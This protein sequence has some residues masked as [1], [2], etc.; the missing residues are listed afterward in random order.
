MVYDYFIKDHLGNTRMTLTE[1]QDSTI[2]QATMETDIT[3]ELLNL[4]AYEESLFLNLV[5]TRDSTLALANH[6]S[7]FGITNNE[8]ARLNGSDSSRRVGPAKLLVVSPGDELSMQVFAYHQGGYVAGDSI[9]QSNLVTALAGAFGGVNGSANSE[10]QA[11]YDLFNQ[12]AALAYVGGAG[13]PNQPLAYLNFI[14]FDQDFNYV[15]AG[16]QQVT[17]TANDHQELNLQK[18]ID[19]GGYIY[20]YLS[21]ESQTDFNVYFDDFRVVHT[22]GA[23]LQE[24]HY[25]PFGMSINAL[26]SSAPLSKPNQF[27]Y[28]GKE[29]DTDFDINWYDY[30]ARMY[31]P[32]VGRWNHI[33]PL[34]EIY[35]TYSP[36]N[37]TLNNP[38]RFIDPNGMAV[39]ETDSSTVYTGDDAASYYRDNI[40]SQQQQQNN[41]GG[42]FVSSRNGNSVVVSRQVGLNVSVGD[43]G[44]I[45][46]TGIYERATINIDPGVNAENLSDYSL[47]VLAE[48]L[49]NSGN[50]ALTITSVERTP[51]GQARAMR[52]NLIANGLQSQLDLY[53]PAGDRVAVAGALFLHFGGNMLPQA[54]R[55]LLTQ[56]VMLNQINA[57]GPTNVSRHVADPRVENIVDISAT[58]TLT[59]VARFIQ[60]LR[61]DPRINQ[62]R[63]FVPPRDPAIHVQVPQTNLGNN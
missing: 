42:G 29:F 5:A 58:R 41:F 24:D 33:D 14:Q 8:T 56:Q 20:V 15:D 32:V 30:E 52:V 54:Q 43:D 17:N 45:S 22:K 4:K 57:E 27:K 60:S 3:P 31:D 21:A 55:E 40:Q 62:G 10:S 36:Y 51:E 11:I 19:T 13:N 35:H 49:M 39:T 18:T 9:G 28:N 59:N 26:S 46:S 6:S 23:I 53:A 61:T 12:N 44:S 38:I 37:Y 1:D 25:Y 7:E 50:S 34:A 47:I 2:Y 16:Y 63:L 48:N